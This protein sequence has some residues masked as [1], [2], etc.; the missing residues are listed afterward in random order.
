MFAARTAGRS[1]RPA[2]RRRSSRRGG[3][4]T[5]RH[6]FDGGC[7]RAGT[8]PV[9]ARRLWRSRSILSR[10]TA[11]WACLPVNVLC[12]HSE[13]P[14]LFAV[15]HP[16]TSSTCTP[17]LCLCVRTAVPAYDLRPARGAD[18]RAAFLGP[19]GACATKEMTC[20]SREQGSIISLGVPAQPKR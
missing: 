18:S 20:R 16:R 6:V 15:V 1:S 4:L 5:D 19:E 11:K 17:S 3:F 9:N 10:A 14:A 13:A 12:V 7:E 2:L 8:S